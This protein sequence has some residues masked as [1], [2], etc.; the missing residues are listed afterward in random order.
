MQQAIGD[1]SRPSTQKAG[2]ACCGV[3]P[4][5]AQTAVAKVELSAFRLAPF[6][7]F[8]FLGGWEFKDFSCSLGKTTSSPT[9]SRFTLTQHS[10]SHTAH[11]PKLEL[12]G[13]QVSTNKSRDL[14]FHRNCRVL[15]FPLLI[16]CK[17][18]AS[19]APLSRF[20]SQTRVYVTTHQQTP[21][22]SAVQQ[23]VSDT[24]RG[25]QSSTPSALTACSKD[26]VERFWFVKGTL[27]RCFKGGS[28]PWVPRIR[29][30]ARIG[31]SAPQQPAC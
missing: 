8:E 2:L 26:L 31:N 13:D 14:G 29:H 1:G 28:R 19:T 27:I 22:R 18:E 4:I 17:L 25:A 10:R 9:S 30:Q 12:V 24:L 23:E 5:I 7:A 11:K 6:S 15:G 21:L 16:V 3:S 20:Q